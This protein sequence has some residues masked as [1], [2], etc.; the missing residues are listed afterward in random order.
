MA[1]TDY[2]GKAVTTNTIAGTPVDTVP[3]T[4]PTLYQTLR[5]FTGN[6]APVA[7]TLY[8]P[9][10]ANSK[11]WF[12]NPAY[13]WVEAQGGAGKLIN[14]WVNPDTADQYRIVNLDSHGS[15]I[16][17]YDHIALQSVSRGL[18]VTANAGQLAANS[19][20]IGAKQSFQLHY[21]TNYMVALQLGSIPVGAMWYTE[22]N[23]GVPYVNGQPAKDCTLSPNLIQ[24]T[25]QQL[26]RAGGVIVLA[27][28]FTTLSEDPG[29]L[30]SAQQEIMSAINVPQCAGVEWELYAGNGDQGRP[31]DNDTL[32]GIAQCAASTK[33]CYVL[34][35]PHNTTDPHGSGSYVK[36][37]SL[38]IERLRTSSITAAQYKLGRIQIVLAAYSRN[39]TG[40][41][42]LG[43]DGNS[44]EAA[45]NWIL[46]HG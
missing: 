8:T 7:P 26:G 15:V 36:D 14:A 32:N 39:L 6:T 23:D 43:T 3:F 20:T 16:R 27:R 12:S 10:P 21:L 19:T 31:I 41:H 28:S 33:K 30:P 11:V 9:L 2:T 13:Y 46:K 4:I 35:A 22:Y 34:L 5:Y 44:V 25:S 29:Y 1:L 37:V 18:Y 45:L 40:V 42:F 24:F 17:P 38:S